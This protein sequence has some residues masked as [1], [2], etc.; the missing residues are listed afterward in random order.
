MSSYNQTK[1]KLLTALQY[2]PT[3]HKYALKGFIVPN[4]TSVIDRFLPFDR[5]AP[6]EVLEAARERGTIVHQLTA[7]LDRHEWTLVLE[8]DTRL[9]GFDGYIQAWEAF[10][11]ETN[12]QIEA[13]EQ[14]VYNDKYRYAGTLDR[15]VRLDG[16]LV[17]LEIKTGLLYPSYKWQTAAYQEAFN[18]GRMDEKATGRLAVQLKVD[19]KYHLEWHKSGA[20]FDAFKGALAITNWENE[21]GI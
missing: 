15:I 17:I 5:G 8:D 9:A 16:K 20:D 6:T 3:K 13:I 12:A 11:L 10:L 14:R 19:G 21:N 18:E 7:K 4:V 1:Q 2:E